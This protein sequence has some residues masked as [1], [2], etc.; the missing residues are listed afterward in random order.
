MHQAVRSV[1]DC[2]ICSTNTIVEGSDYSRVAALRPV[3][4]RKQIEIVASSEYLD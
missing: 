1:E 2:I 3:Q 4:C